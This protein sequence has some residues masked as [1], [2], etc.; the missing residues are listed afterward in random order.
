MLSLVQKD[1]EEEGKTQHRGSP[2]SVRSA[3]C[4][5]H[6]RFRGYLWALGLLYSLESFLFSFSFYDS[7]LEEWLA[8]SSTKIS[9]MGC[10]SW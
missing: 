8:L 6:L 4:L 3:A 2:E 9:P 7:P 1:V 10:A 5:F